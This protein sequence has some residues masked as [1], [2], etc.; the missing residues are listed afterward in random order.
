MVV[1]SIRPWVLGP[2]PFGRRRRRQPAHLHCRKCTYVAKLAAIEYAA[3]PVG[4]GAPRRYWTLEG[5]LCVSR[6]R[7]HRV[8]SSSSSTAGA[9]RSSAEAAEELADITEQQVR[10]V[11][12]GP[13]AAAV[14]LAP[15][16]D[17]GV[18]A[19][20]EPA[21]RSE[22]EGEAGQADGDGGRPGR[23]CGVLVLV[24]EAGRRRRGV[25]QPV[26]RDV[27]DDVVLAQGVAEQ[28]AAP[29]D[30]PGRGVGQR[31]RDRLGLRG[32]QLV[33]DRVID[34]ALQELQI[35]QLLGG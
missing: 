29:G 19:F 10:S 23:L 31:V 18:V 27:G 33:V 34:E 24:V 21:D 17:V 32:L 30:L 20:G 4:P 7:G 26:D 28:L 11:V 5:F 16:D 13:V 35:F 14:E 2:A 6:R 25:G 15:G 22:V 9:A 1:T 12:G 3:P 8:W